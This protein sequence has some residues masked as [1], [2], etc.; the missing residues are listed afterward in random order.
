MARA[1]EKIAAR[2]AKAEAK[3]RHLQADNQ[4]LRAEMQRLHAEMLTIVEE[5]RVETRSRLA[6]A[7]KDFAA[8]RH[9][10][11]SLEEEMSATSPTS[12][13]RASGPAVVRP[14]RI[15]NTNRMVQNELIPP[16]NLGHWRCWLHRISPL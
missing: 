4:H 9:R 6:G 11:A 15:L 16:Q 12:P 7:L 5:N 1:S 10:L 3:M 8:M 14:A 2:G 13:P